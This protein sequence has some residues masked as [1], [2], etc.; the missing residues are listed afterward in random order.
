[1]AT[2]PYGWATKSTSGSG[3][4]INRFGS[5]FDAAKQG[6]MA[7]Q[8]RQNYNSQQ[9][10]DKMANYNQ[11]SAPGGIMS[12]QSQQGY[13][14]TREQPGS[15]YGQGARSLQ[16]YGGQ[17]V[18]DYQRRQYE[19]QQRQYSQYQ[20]SGQYAKDQANYYQ[21]NAQQWK[22][23]NSAYNTKDLSNRPPGGGYPNP[24]GIT[25]KGS[26][27]Y[28]NL[29]R[30]F[31]GETGDLS[32]VTHEQ[33]QMLDAA[34]MRGGGY[35]NQQFG[36]NQYDNTPQFS[37]GGNQYG[38][39]QYGG[40]QWGSLMEG[41]PIY[42]GGQQFG[43]NQYGP[44]GMYATRGDGSQNRMMPSSGGQQFGGVQQFGG[45]QYGGGQAG[46]AGISMGGGY[47][48]GSQYPSDPGGGY[49]NGGP[50]YPTP[51]PTY[52]GGPAAPTNPNANRG[53][54]NFGF[55]GQ[56]GYTPGAGNTGLTSNTQPGPKGMNGLPTP[57]QEN[58]IYS[59]PGNSPALRDLQ[60]V[61]QE[62]RLGDISWLGDKNNRMIA[63]DYANYYGIPI[64]N[65]LLQAQEQQT[66]KEQFAATY[67]QQ[68]KLNEHSMSMDDA[69]NERE[70]TALDYSIFKDQRDFEQSKLDFEATTGFNYD[71]LAAEVGM[72][73]ANNQLNKYKIDTEAG[74]T[75]AR[76]G[77]DYAT[78]NEQSKQAM[79]D[80]ALKERT[81][82]RLAT[83]QSMDERF[84]YSELEQNY[85]L[86][87][88]QLA[89]QLMQSRYSTFGRA[90]GPNFR[91]IG[92]WK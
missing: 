55:S 33:R 78:L 12:N 80:L 63:E 51:T 75:A 2:N 1:M 85:K 30:Q 76:L 26:A 79:R 86:M 54:G 69:A 49:G 32:R 48:D 40:G 29:V 3:S 37:V 92:S 87:Q 73:E 25:G 71:K 45:N 20:N 88:Q 21:S 90:Q 42:G 38:G 27:E 66:A 61:W 60:K 19:E 5:D 43:G 9:S 82:G 74:A 28:Q 41:A 18:A 53:P 22:D 84:R 16:P 52:N 72:N 65:L 15:S 17:G 4:N 68:N 59:T 56:Y 47:G 11:K 35:G 64:S 31:G 46:A 44:G 23:P 67:A 81:E 50:A 83:Q 58:P 89:N 57:P 62:G 36:G 39:N 7:A 70:N 6:M 77:F 8:D 13:A 34:R 91:A 24:M 10:F 14:Q